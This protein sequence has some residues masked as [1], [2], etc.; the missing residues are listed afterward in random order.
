MTRT[1]LAV[2]AICSFQLSSAH[3]QDYGAMLQQYMQQNNALTQQMQQTQNAIVSQNMNNPQV[4]AMYQ[5]HRAQGGTMSFEQFAYQ[6]AATAGFT[7]DGIARYNQSERGIQQR[8]AQSI[9]AYR[10]NQARN[11]QAQQQMYQEQNERFARQRGNVL[12]GT[13]DYRDPSNGQSYNL[14]NTGA[15]GAGYYDPYSQQNFYQGQGNSFYRQDP[16]G[17]DYELEEEE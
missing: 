16:N 11:A 10:D 12:S 17:Y 1:I 4:Q 14:P 9:Q 8:D 7:P 5:Q 13:S 2:L 15:P 3:A 6:Y